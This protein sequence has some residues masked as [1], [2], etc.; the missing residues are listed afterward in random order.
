VFE[1]INAC[2]YYPTP[3]PSQEVTTPTPTPTPTITETPTNTP[4]VT[5][6]ETPTNT[7]TVTPTVTPSITASLTPS[8][9][10][11]FTPT[12][13]ATNPMLFEVG[14][15]FD[16]PAQTI[17]YDS[18]DNTIFV[19]GQF[20]FFNTNITRYIAKMSLD[21]VLD[22]TFVSKFVTQSGSNSIFCLALD[23]TYIWAG[24]LFTQTYD[25]KDVTNLVKIN[26]TTGDID[27]SFKTGTTANGFVNSIILDGTKAVITG[28]F[29]TY[30][31]VSRNRI[32]RINNDGTLDTTITFGTGFNNPV[33]KIIMNN[34]GNYV[35]VGTFTALNGG[36]VNRIVEINSTTGVNTGLFGTGFNGAVQDIVYDSSN[37]I[38]YCLTN[39]TITYR[40]GSG[41]QIHK[42]NGT[43][44]E[45][46]VAN[47][48]TG[49]VPSTLYM[50]F[51]NDHL[52]IGK[53]GVTQYVRGFIST[54]TG[55]SPFD[56]NII[57]VNN[58]PAAAG[59][60]TM[61][62]QNNFPYFVGLFTSFYNQNFNHIVRTNANGTN[63]ST[64]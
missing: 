35:V 9:T 64:L 59:R 12:P 55:D 23:S 48:A 11:T 5:P 10:P 3:T 27:P 38:Y 22:P 42:I 21:G 50:D 52:Y 58:G 31:G 47:I 62:V 44:T 61:L 14:Q 1:D 37:D 43:G 24:G 51:P 34:A 19:G 6:T 25:G 13:S 36:T 16:L 17:K 57:G 15:G 40:G 32:A 46:A 26:K 56:D 7:P 60:D 49:V 54:L 63:N 45:V 41:G 53:G 33:N 30:S 4:S 8:V 20:S 28:A 29:T 18:D 2:D 39:D